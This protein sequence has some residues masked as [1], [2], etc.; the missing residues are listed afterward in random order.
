M[1][2][3][4]LMWHISVKTWPAL[5]GDVM[6]FGGHELMPNLKSQI[7]VQCLRCANDTT[8]GAYMH[9][10]IHTR[11]LIHTHTSLGDILVGVFRGYKN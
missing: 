7:C 6:T 5:R 9:T 10:H 3:E 2:W 11:S 1:T 8:N 4:Y